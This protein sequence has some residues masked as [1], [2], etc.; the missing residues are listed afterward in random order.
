MPHSETGLS[1]F[2]MLYGMPYKHGMPVG[3]PQI[4]NGQIQPYLI[5]VN[6]NLQ[7]LRKHG[8][9]TQ[10]NPLGFAIHK[11]QPGDKVLI[12]TWREVPLPPH[13]EGPFLVL[14]TTDT[15]IRTAEKGWTHASRVKK[16]ELQ[17]CTPEWKVSS[18]PGDLKIKLQRHRK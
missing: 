12:K 6:K 18:S 3:H 9:I 16:I 15:A 5:A 2:E 17:D 13:W 14:L 1:P 4:E 7:D 11:R 8:L 10:S